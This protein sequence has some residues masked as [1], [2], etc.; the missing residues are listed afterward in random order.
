[1]NSKSFREA[2]AAGLCKASTLSNSEHSSEPFTVPIRMAFQPIVNLANNSTFAY[3]ALVRGL[4]GEGAGTILAQ[5]NDSNRSGFDVACRAHALTQAFSLGLQNGG[6]S[7]AVNLSS[8]SIEDP[9]ACIEQTLNLAHQLQFPV[10]RLIFELT[11]EERWID[12]K[13]LNALLRSFREHG[14]RVAI[15]DFGSGYAGLGMLAEIETDIVKIDISLVRNVDRLVPNCA[16]IE[17]IVKCA[18]RMK[19]LV[20]AEG[21]ETI[22]ECKTLVELGMELMQGYYFAKP[23]LGRLPAWKLPDST[24]QSQ[25]GSGDPCSRH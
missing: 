23:K 18:N 22:E 21:V 6:S 3:E 14:V 11:E 15:D 19:I 9:S 24:W 12:R 25:T 5:V 16:I 13:F 8:G 20:I 10:S 4:H 2:V 7:L 1:M 17:S